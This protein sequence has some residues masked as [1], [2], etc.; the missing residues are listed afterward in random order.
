MISRQKWRKNVFEIQSKLFFNDCCKI[1]GKYT[2]Y[3]Y[4]PKL[5]NAIFIVSTLSIGETAAVLAVSGKI[6]R[7]KQSLVF[8][9]G[10]DKM[11]AGSF[12]S[13]GGILST[14]VAFLYQHFYRG[15]YIRL[16]N[17]VK[18]KRTFCSVFSNYLLNFCNT[19]MIIG[20]NY[21]VY[22]CTIVT[23]IMHYSDIDWSYSTRLF[24]NIY[25]V[26]V[27]SFC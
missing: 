11:F 23:Y 21:Y 2:Q 19:E 24:N 4:R 18:L 16:C 20:F 10:S 1:F 26:L 13:F 15:C 17:S 8:V 22:S 9:R 5:W 12:T 7:V 6:S 14:P 27:K 25:I 3:T